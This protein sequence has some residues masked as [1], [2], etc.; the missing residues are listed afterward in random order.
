VSQLA[1]VGTIAEH[2]ACSIG[3]PTGDKTWLTIAPPTGKANLRLVAPYE[4]V[5]TMRASVLALG[6]L[7]AHYSRARTSLPAGAQSRAADRSALR[8][9]RGDG[10]Q[11]MLD[12]GYVDVECNRLKG[13]M[14]DVPR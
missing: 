9:P 14:I 3:P 13:A 10:R 5:K 6:A 2:L 12:H 11:G 4:Q 1:A 8:G 7:A